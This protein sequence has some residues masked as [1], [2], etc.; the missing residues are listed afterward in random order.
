[1]SLRV[2]PASAGDAAA[3]GQAGY[4]A[5]L[6]GISP[7]VPAEA[8]GRVTEESFASFVREIPEQILI[9]ERAGVV[10]GLGA[11]ERGDN[12]IS[13]IWVAPGH[14]GAG[15]GTAL[16]RDLEKRIADRGYD[17]VT[18]SVLSDNARALSLYRHLGY[19]LVSKGPEF[20]I[21]LGC[22]LETSFLMK[23]LTA[24]SE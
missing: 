15:I 14:E 5:W 21:H 16:V 10:A 4:A 24:G 8:R 9:A 11:T 20:D 12:H 18:I 3:A 1:M 6:K 19:G 22:D 7:I 23:D 13:D 2:R 17:N